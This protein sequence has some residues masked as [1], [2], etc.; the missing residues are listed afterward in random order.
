VTRA[1]FDAEAGAE[2]WRAG[3]VL[4]VVLVPLLVAGL[5]GW[6]LATPYQDLERVTAAVVNADDPVQV[7][8]QTVPL[9][10]EFAGQ[11]IGGQA[12]TGA[13]QDPGSDATASPAPAGPNFTWVLT[14]EQDAHAGLDDGT[15]AAIVRIPP[16]FS[17]DATSLSGPP[18]D[19]V[20]ATVHI[21][22]TPAT[23][24]LDPAL[25]D[26]VVEA[27]VT[28][29]NA[30]L[31]ARYL[32]NLYDGFNQIQA[33]IA[34]AAD[35]AG[36]LA[37]GADSLAAGADQLAEGAD[38]VAEGADD[39][40][41]GAS[42]LAAGA[43]RLEEGLDALA[44]GAASLAAGLGEL[45]SSVQGLPGE[46]ARLAAGAAEVAAGLDAEA[47]AV[48]GAVDAFAAL[49]DDL[50]A[51]PAQ[52]GCA[53]GTELVA[54]LRG[55]QADVAAL[56][57]GANQVAAGNASLAAGMPGLVGGVDSAAAGGTGVADGARDSAAG[58]ES[59]TEG[60]DA[61]AEGADSLAEG[62]DEVADGAGSLADGAAQVDEGA[63]DLAD[64]LQSAAGQ[65]PTYSTSDISTLSS[66]G[67]RPVE[68]ALTA[69]PDGV[70]S[71][72]LFAAVG[73][74]VGGIVIALARRAVP[75]R[76]LMTAAPTAW[77]AG[78]AIRPVAALG[79]LQGLA[80]GAVLAP[81][82][83]VGMRERVG[84]VGAC[85]LV[86]VAFAA[87]NHGLA[88]ALGGIGRTL[89][90]AIGV[91]ALAVGTSSTVPSALEGAATVAPTEP[92]RR[93]LLA[94]LGIGT[95]WGAF[96]ALVV[97][98]LAGLAL[99]TAGVARRRTRPSPEPAR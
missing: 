84:L 56:A 21:V 45:R 34:Q 90:V 95:G 28:S 60:A 74:W 72:P 52:P 61:L 89:A 75:A 58:G 1:A 77:V 17:A 91:V 63:G 48:A 39:A 93:L 22:T 81:F 79:A 85:L 12:G 55:A 7:N 13:A 88:A 35:D 87:V 97:F 15:Y 80:V 68:T 14:N 82:V 10:R 76:W 53:R 54:T 16:S 94:S 31:T 43:A 57:A 26:V 3:A 67:A 9:G 2:R 27:A 33:S 11:L 78:R 40:A 42:R 69:P 65:I 50:C 37:S 46:T 44:G 30:E 73:L 8:G 29:L 24:F 98:T 92:G 86:G 71:V 19:A 36:E 66:V 47:A 32:G 5:L 62:A 4:G 83:D 18:A 70:V 49:V 6:A 41:A 23:A 96:T 99:A 20:A 25:T 64:G 59:L 51:R 38:G